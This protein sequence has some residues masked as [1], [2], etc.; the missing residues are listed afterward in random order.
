MGRELKLIR[1][2]IFDYQ[3][4]IQEFGDIEKPKHFLNYLRFKLD[5]NPII[6]KDEKI[7]K[8]KVKKNELRRIQRLNRRSSL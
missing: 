7:R 4:L 8:R 5:L 2:F 3:D 6:N 1:K